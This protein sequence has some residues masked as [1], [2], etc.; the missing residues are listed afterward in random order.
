MTLEKAELRRHAESGTALDTLGRCSAPFDDTVGCR[1]PHPRTRADTMIPYNPIPYY[2]TPYRPSVAV[3]PSA[4]L[5]V[6]CVL[7]DSAGLRPMRLYRP[8]CRRRGLSVDSCQVP[9]ALFTIRRR[10]HSTRL[11][12]D[13]QWLY[14]E[15]DLRCNS[16]GP[17]VASGDTGR[18]PPSR[19]S[20][21]YPAVSSA[22]ARRGPRGKPGRGH[23]RA[24]A[25]AADL[26]RGTSRSHAG[27]GGPPRGVGGP[28]ELL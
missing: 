25:R 10:K 28:S 2:T 16:R 1:H 5:Q 11:L 27:F 18:R 6:D 17:K 22:P 14:I 24:R 15:G 7:V 21:R 8:G 12:S 20:A 3:R 9:I 4:D 26:A 19:P 13:S 23:E